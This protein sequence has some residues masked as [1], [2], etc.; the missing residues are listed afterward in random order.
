MITIRVPYNYLNS[1]KVQELK[2]N[3]RKERRWEF[4]Y[5]GNY[6]RNGDQNL[7]VKTFDEC[8]TEHLEA[9]L[10]TQPH[11]SPIDKATILELLKERWEKRMDC[12]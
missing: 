10:I 7:E 11:L 1:R 6:G 12:E 5:W 2:T 3:V 9:I 4:A 8:D